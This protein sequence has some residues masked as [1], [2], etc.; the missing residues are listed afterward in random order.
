MM[1]WL[2]CLCLLALACGTYIIWPSRWNVF[3]HMQLGFSLVAYIIPILVVHVPSRFS[4]QLL[5]KDL[6]IL[7]L[8]TIVYLSG[9][10]IGSLLNGVSYIPIRLIFVALH[11]RGVLRVVE[12]R[13]KFLLLTALVLLALCFA[14][15]RFIPAFASDPFAAKF[16]RGSYAIRYRPVAIPFRTAYSIIEAMIPIAFV[17]WWQTRKIT[18]LFLSLCSVLAMALCLT[19]GPVAAGGLLVLGLICARRRIWTIGYLLLLLVIYP[20]GSAFYSLLGLESNHISLWRVIANGAPDV[21]DQLH[22]LRGFLSI[23]SWTWGKTFWGGLIPYHYPWNPSIY[24]L[25]I[26][27]GYSNVNKV[28]SGGLRLP[29]P[30]WGFAAFGWWGVIGVSLLSGILM[31]QS[32]N[33]MKRYVPSESPLQSVLAMGVFSS[34]NMIIVQFY[35][36]SIYSLPPLLITVIF[37]YAVLLAPADWR[38]SL[39]S[40]WP[41]ALSEPS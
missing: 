32:V 25:D 19:R 3:A 21:S 10:L 7:G 17:L 14:Y 24:S 6:D 2:L 36:L 26:I 34:V 12:R 37:S 41:S 35:S 13:A 39:S 8:G 4:A 20:I 31:G 38:Y 27:N 40:A 28:V 5:S 22:F 16:F 15:M 1:S 23:G 9:L 33:F 30:M 29:L 18:W 11:P